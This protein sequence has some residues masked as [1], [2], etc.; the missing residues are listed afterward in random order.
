MIFKLFKYMEKICVV[1]QFI[2]GYVINEL[3][4]M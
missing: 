3:N 4:I 2:F 1:I